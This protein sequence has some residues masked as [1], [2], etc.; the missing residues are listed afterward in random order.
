M[1]NAVR[2]LERVRKIL[3]QSVEHAKPLL[4]QLHPSEIAQVLEDISP[5]SRSK[6]IRMLPIETA[7][8]A[9]SE[10]DEET[11]PEEILMGISPL[12]AA[13]IIEELDPDDAADILSQM[14]L[15][16][17]RLIMERLSDEE[18]QVIASLMTY[19]ED[20]AGGIMN[21]EVLRIPAEWT[22]REAIEEVIQ[23]SEEMEDFYAIYIV[24]NEERLVGVV[25]LKDLIRA[26]PWVKVKEIML[27]Q[28]VKVE[29]TMDQEEVAALIK[30]YNL[31]AVP[32][33]DVEGRLLGRITFDDVLDVLEEENTEDMLKLVGVSEEE[34]LRGGWVAS[35][36]SRLPWLLINLCTASAAGFVIS[37][38][39]NTL[40]KLVI[41]AS[42][43]P[44][45]AGVAGNGATQALAV[46]IRRIATDGIPP[47]LYLPV[48]GKE[49]AVGFTNG[50][51]LGLT[52]GTFAWSLNAN[53]MLGMVVFMALVGNLLIAGFAGSAVPLFLQRLGVD[54]AVASSILMTAFTD[55]LGYSLLLG[56]SSMLLL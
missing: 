1:S 27:E 34:S 33:V 16:D 49:L 28:L 10:M 21:P 6:I 3:T 2:N 20:S 32:V 23:I 45:V 29:V 55:I 42:F 7:S 35:V 12:R 47:R 15:E 46:T 11:N 18:E 40:D 53:P 31:P 36:R 22:K 48:I 41:V 56:L 51:I 52:V 8:E 43:M 14:P 38:F 37:M 19:D 50:V 4:K 13:Q 54:P 5:E 25:S 24:D 39:S 30:Q 9:L 44:I 17:L 26:R